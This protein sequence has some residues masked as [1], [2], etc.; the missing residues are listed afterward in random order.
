MFYS[1]YSSITNNFYRATPMNSYIR[2]LHASPNA[3]NIDIYADGNLIVAK[4]CL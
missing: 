3:P 2:I 1:P 4:S